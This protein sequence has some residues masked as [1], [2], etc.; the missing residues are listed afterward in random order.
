M[1]S[2]R[3]I[4][5]IGKTKTVQ[6]CTILYNCPESHYLSFDGVN[7]NIGLYTV[8]GVLKLKISGRIFCEKLGLIWKWYTIERGCAFYKQTI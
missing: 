8:S 2:I 4:N 5:E 6:S 1:F 7:T 3:W